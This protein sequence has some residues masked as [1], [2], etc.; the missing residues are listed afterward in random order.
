MNL[1]NAVQA[2]ELTDL[3][4]ENNFL[5]FI[6]EEIKKK[7]FLGEHKLTIN[8]NES[9]YYQ[10]IKHMNELTKLGYDVEYDFDDIVIGW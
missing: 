8:N 1:F 3:C 4:E 5:L 6:T 7:A 9:N 10:V 2:R